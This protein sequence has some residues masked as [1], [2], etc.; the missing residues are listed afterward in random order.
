MSRDKDRDIEQYLNTGELMDTLYISRSTVNRLVKRG[1]PHIWVG[2]TRRFLLA[3][4]IKWLKNDQQ[5][6]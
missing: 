2:S 6:N 5:K 3:E 1:L 4:I